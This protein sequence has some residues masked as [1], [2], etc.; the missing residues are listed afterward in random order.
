MIVNEVNE[1][2]FQ[3]TL[4]C[5]RKMVQISEAKKNLPYSKAFFVVVRFSGFSLSSF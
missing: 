5:A 2:I 3:A 1:T 4:T